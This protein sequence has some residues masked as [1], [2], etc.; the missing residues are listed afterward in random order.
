VNRRIVF[1]PQAEQEVLGAWDWYRERRPETGRAFVDEFNRCID[2]I[3]AT[4]E[5][6]PKM[7]GE[8]RRALLRRFPYAIFYRATGEE[9]VVLACFHVRRNP[10]AWRRRR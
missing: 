6:F 10:A 4:P 8:I 1:R 7:E 2:R 9:I 5:T 3:A